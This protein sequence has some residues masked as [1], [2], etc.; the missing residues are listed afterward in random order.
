MLLFF[1]ADDFF[2]NTM[3][4]LEMAKAIR[5]V[6]YILALGALRQHETLQN[7]I[8]NLENGFY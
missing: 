2:N 3:D 5:Q 6:N 7:E 1:G 8:T 4:P